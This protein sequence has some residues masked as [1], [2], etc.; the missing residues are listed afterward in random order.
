MSVKFTCIFS[1]DKDKGATFEITSNEPRKFSTND[2]IPTVQGT[3]AT[4]NIN[5]TEYY[6]KKSHIA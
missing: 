6:I 1:F 2:P 3:T 4:V 5:I